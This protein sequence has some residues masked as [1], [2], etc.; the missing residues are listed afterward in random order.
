MTTYKMT[1][2]KTFFASGHF[3]GSC[4]FS[5]WFFHI[6]EYNNNNCFY[7]LS[8][9]HL[10]VLL[11]GMLPVYLSFS[12]FRGPLN[13]PPLLQNGVDKSC[14]AGKC[15][16]LGPAVLCHI[17]MIHVVLDTMTLCETLMTT[18]EAVQ[19]CDRVMF[20]INNIMHSP[21]LIV[22]HIFE[23]QQQVSACYCC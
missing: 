23:R 12:T 5:K 11:Q 13:Q 19:L 9:L 1:R 16:I 15:D 6:I 21:S 7:T 14:F 17:T 2:C 4:N 10:N 20:P 18:R 3:I 22:C 8:K